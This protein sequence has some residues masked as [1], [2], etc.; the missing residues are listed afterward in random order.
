MHKIEVDGHIYEFKTMGELIKFLQTH[1][2][3]KNIE[4]VT[5][6]NIKEETSGPRK[7]CKGRSNSPS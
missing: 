5:R 6:A 4:E 3:K 2:S 7:T 1:I